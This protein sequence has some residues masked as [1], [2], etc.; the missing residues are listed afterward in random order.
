MTKKLNE[1]NE[2][3]LSKPEV[4]AK[5]GFKTGAVGIIVHIV[6][7]L[8]KIISGLLSGAV[9]IVSDGINN[10][11]DAGSSIISLF[12]FKLSEKKPDTEHPI[13]HGRLVYACDNLRMSRAFYRRQVLSCRS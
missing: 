9:S 11:S 10:F 2:E 3:E 13:G 5:F 6:L 7:C 1:F 8:A 12:G 4:R